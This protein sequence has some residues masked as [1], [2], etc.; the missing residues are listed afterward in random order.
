MRVALLVLVLCLGIST[1]QKWT[2]EDNWSGSNFLANFDFWSSGDPT[3]GYVHYVTQAVAQQNGLLNISGNTVF[4]YTDHT[5]KA[6]SPGRMSVRIS[7]KK[8][9][10]GGLFVFDL[11]HMPTGCGNWP[12]IWTC[13]P[14]WPNG[15]EIDIIEGV[16]T[17]ANNA[18]TLH[19]NQGCTMANVARTQKGKVSGP[20]C[21]VGDPGQPSNAGCG[22]TATTGN[23]FGTGFNNNQG[24]VY[25]MEWTSAGVNIFFFPRQNIPADLKNDMPNPSG[26]GT[27]EASFPFGS[28]CPS[29]HFANHQIILDNTLCG[30]WAGAV[31]GS[32]GCTGSCN[33][34]VQNN[35]QAFTQAYWAINYFKTYKQG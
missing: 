15:G 2:L 22:V 6:T 14:G 10:N 21:W 8:T 17:Q 31:F 16:N 24:G 19:T 18:M 32:N 26:W 13:G 4:I 3:H 11:T 1:A 23:S 30:D 12:A 35:P 20:D 9:Y 33:T 28:N 27:P 29:S 5:N 25:A 34:F 7:S